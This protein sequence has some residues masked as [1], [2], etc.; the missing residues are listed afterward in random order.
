MTRSRF[1]Q[2][3][4]PA[5]FFTTA[6][7]NVS[8]VTDGVGHTH[9]VRRESQYRATSVYCRP[10]PAARPLTGPTR[11]TDQQIRRSISGKASRTLPAPAAAIHWR[12]VAMRQS[13]VRQMP[14]AT[15]ATS[16]TASLAPQA[17]SGA[18]SGGLF[19]IIFSCLPREPAIF[20]TQ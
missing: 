15:Q 20:V 9:H 10:V 2:W 11:P 16:T 1:T 8:T 6:Q 14:A 17:S 3:Y 13:N 18:G 4:L 12:V 19:R 5:V 7:A